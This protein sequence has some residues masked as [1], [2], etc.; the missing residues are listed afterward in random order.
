MSVPLTMLILFVSAKLLAEAAERLRQ[1]GIVGE[2]LA[3]I[4]IGPSVLNWLAPTELLQGMAEMGAMFLLFRVGLEVRAHELLKVGLTATLVAICGVVVPFAAGFGAVQMWG[5]NLNQAVFVGASLVA[6]SVGVTAQVLASRGLLNELSSKVILAA[7]VIDDVLGL[8]VLA[9]VSS[10]SRGHVNVLQLSMTCI[11]AGAFT[12]VV[13]KWGTVAMRT[14][15]PKAH[16]G[17][18]QAESRFVFALGLLLALSVL[19]VWAGVAAIVGA[20]LAGLA[21][22]DT[23]EQR[24]RDLAQ[25]VSELL[26]PF[27]LVGIGLKVDLHAL[28]Q[29]QTLAFAGVLVAVA[30]LSKFV[31]CGIG[32]LRLGRKQALRIGIGM[33]PRGE[34]G[35][36]VAQIGLSSAILTRPL[37]SV[38]VCMSVATTMVAPPLIQLAFPS[39][40]AREEEE[41]WRVA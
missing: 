17:L 24:E 22:A 19:A 9:G 2:I 16:R 35:M 11:L 30:V 10:L 18:K 7:A 12:F 27:F 15:A 29:P 34:V 25:G 13:A 1:P 28:L 23:A 14:I 6:T 31:G 37:Y 40:Q 8:L 3:G 36:I 5:G 20:F 38:V 33:I 41:S 32:A 39:K 21:L 26:V 4:L